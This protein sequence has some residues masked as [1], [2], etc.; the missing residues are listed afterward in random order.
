MNRTL[1]DKTRC[2]LINSKLHRSFWAEAI[3]TASYL[4]NKSPSAAIGFKT[5]EELWSRKPG[6][7]EHL[8]VFGCPAY[9]NV[10]Q[11]KLDARAIK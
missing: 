11:G 10:R 9:V 6:R 4:V 2:L 5:P 8:R 1:I 7:Y 3:Y